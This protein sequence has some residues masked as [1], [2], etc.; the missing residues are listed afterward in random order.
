MH[1]TR[2]P[3]AYPSVLNSLK[4]KLVGKIMSENISFRNTIIALALPILLASMSSSIVN[5]A[6]PNMVSALQTTFS[7]VQWV[8]IAYLITLT[9]SALIVGYFSDNRDRR[10]LLLKGMAIFILGSLLCALAPSITGLILFRIVQGIGAAI[11]LNTTMALIADL[12]S[13]TSSGLAMG[14]VGTLS[15][16]GTMIGPI[17]GGTLSEIWGWWAIFWLNIPMGILAFIL[18]CYFIEPNKVTQIAQKNH[19]ILGMLTLSLTLVLY[20]LALT[21]GGSWTIPLMVITLLSLSLFIYIE[22]RAITPLI[23]LILFKQIRL[24]AGVATSSIVA[25]IMMSTLI[26]GPFYL[27]HVL[28]L[29]L[30]EAGLVMSCGPMIAALLGL[31]AGKLVDRF[32]SEPIIIIALIGLFMGFSI[33]SY[34]ADILTVA[35]YLILICLITSSY[36]LFQT[37]NNTSV[38]F[39]TSIK[40][41][42]LA[43]LLNLSRNLG[44]IN[45]AALMGTIF[46]LSSGYLGNNIASA[47]YRIAYGLSIT[48]AIAA[49]LVF[50]AMIISLSSLWVTK[51]KHTDK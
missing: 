11:M 24:S 20:S 28:Q 32:G 43:G 18:V 22:T 47:D 35:S 26:V 4:I 13:K 49:L 3:P 15:A 9:A 1:I 21:L 17:V 29:T 12:K 34:F 14:W 45:G 51:V 30:F 8:I 38:M 50:I 2:L 16:L 5:I 36:A 7:Q 25:T 44:L 23:P 33:L 40:R 19:D 31:P 48:F 10:A 46:A 27:T 41:G 37:A 6:I 39:M 42:L